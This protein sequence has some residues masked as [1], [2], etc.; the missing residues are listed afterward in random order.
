[1]RNIRE[2]VRPRGAVRQWNRLL[3]EAMKSL[4]GDIQ[5]RKQTHICHRGGNSRGK[6]RSSTPTD[7]NDLVATGSQL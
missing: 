6:V 4:I 2:N 3:G 5:G 7:F 1:M